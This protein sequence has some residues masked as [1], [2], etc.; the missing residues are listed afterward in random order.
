MLESNPSIIVRDNILCSDILRLLQR[1]IVA[2]R[3]KNYCDKAVCNKISSVIVKSNAYGKYANAPQIGRVGQ[4]FFET[5]ASVNY[6]N[7]Y[8]ENALDWIK[9]LRDICSPYLSPIDKLR[10]QLDELW[11]HGVSLGTIGGRKM[12]AG[13]VREFSIGSEAEPHTD[14]IEWDVE[15][16]ED[17]QAIVSQLAWN[18]Y[19]GMPQRGGELVF[20]DFWPTQVEYDRLR[21]NNSYGLNT[22]LLPDPIVRI[23]PEV[24]EMI[25]FNPL[26]VHAVEKITEG[27]RVSWSCFIGYKGEDCPLI[28][29]S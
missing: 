8:F 4:A 28:V 12:F 2:I 11:P 9:E 25:I 10:L 21:K 14:S 3:I 19:L 1:E 27:S 17:A 26:R 18:T 22:S 7:K 23:S 6:Y 20:W 13:L 24:G 15:K 29:W 16:E 5:Q